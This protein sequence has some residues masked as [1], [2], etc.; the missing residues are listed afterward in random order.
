MHFEGNYGRLKD[1]AWKHIFPEK[2]GKKEIRW[3]LCN[4]VDK[5]FPRKLVAIWVPSKKEESKE[6][7][8]KY[9]IS[10]QYFDESYKYF[11]DSYKYFDGSYKYFDESYKYLDESYK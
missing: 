3:K 2:I 6:E 8:K 11:D 9:N 1:Q 10:Q 7:E 4:V 5:N